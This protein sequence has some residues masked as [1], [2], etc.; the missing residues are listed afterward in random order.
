MTA[1]EHLELAHDAMLQYQKDHHIAE[2]IE[3]LDWFEI[4]ATLAK[5]R[6]ALEKK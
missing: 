6:M 4:M 1:L 5:A 3:N 2:S